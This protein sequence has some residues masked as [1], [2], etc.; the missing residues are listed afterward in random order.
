MSSLEVPAYQEKSYALR[1]AGLKPSRYILF[2]DDDG[3]GY[4]GKVTSILDWEDAI[5]VP[6]RRGVPELNLANRVLDV[7]IT[8]SAPDQFERIPK[9]PGKTRRVLPTVFT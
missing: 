2:V 9:I 7:V 1:H 6:L 5:I 3:G 8:I 4:D